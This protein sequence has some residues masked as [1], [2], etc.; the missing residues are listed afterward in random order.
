MSTIPERHV[1]VGRKLAVC[2]DC[3][4]PWPCETITEHRRAE[5]A[6]RARDALAEDDH[7]AVAWAEA[8]EQDAARLAEAGRL[9]KQ[10]GI[11]DGEMD[12]ALRLHDER[13]KGGTT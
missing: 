9:W 2:F 12:A 3:T 10:H 1:P 4:K 8:A 13:V 5:E 6:L 7:A 11:D